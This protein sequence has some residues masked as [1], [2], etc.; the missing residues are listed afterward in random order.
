VRVDTLRIWERRYGVVGPRLSAGRQRLYSAADIKR[1]TLIKQLVDMGHPIGT[2]AALPDDEIAHIRAGAMPD[3][4]ALTRD[5]S[6]TRIALVGSLLTLEQVSRA[7]AGTEA[8]IVASSPDPDQAMARF[9]GVAADVILIELPTLRDSD[10]LRVA[11][12]KSASGASRAIVLYRFAPSAVVR[13]MRLAGHAVAHATSD[14]FEL[15]ALCL[16]F[17]R[18]APGGAS[19]AEEASEPRPPRFDERTLA[20]L[21]GASR[22]LECECPRHLVDLVMSLASFER[23]STEC[24]SRTPAD[25]ALHIELQRAAGRARSTMEQ[26]LEYVAMADGV[27][28][29]PAPEGT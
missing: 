8:R 5:A 27:V 4:P 28:L 22:T 16:G 6:E 26:A 29:P 10:L 12:I 15:E 7:L 21:A 20:D 1:L 14:P 11:S 19:R 2:I 9:A 17:L 23:Y 3:A 25:A 24:A 18:R 13:R